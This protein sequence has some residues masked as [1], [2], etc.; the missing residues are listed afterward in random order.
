MSKEDWKKNT[1]VNIFKGAKKWPWKKDE[2]ISV[3]DVAC[4][5]S[6]KSKYIPAKIRL[7]VDIYP[8]YFKHIESDVP[9]AVIK[10]DVRKLKDLFVDKS[11]DIVIALDV[12]E[13]L[14]KEESLKMM[15]ELERIARKAVII[16]TP[17]GYV[18][19]DMDIQGHGGHKWQTHRS[20]WEVKDFTKRGY[21]V[22]VRDYKMQN[23]KRHSKIDVGTDIKLIDAIKF[24]K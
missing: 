3:L 24:I 20:G 4:G 2:I 7:G 21:E 14:K 18:P 8:E 9:Y 5:L 22:V 10:Y 1:L 11:F 23:V 13:H 19:Q 16:E 12:V 15:K 17:E 6:L